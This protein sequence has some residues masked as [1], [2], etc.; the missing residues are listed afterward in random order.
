M[1]WLQQWSCCSEPGPVKLLLCPR[2][3]NR[4]VFGS[5]HRTWLQL[6]AGW[7]KE[8]PTHRHQLQLNATVRPICR[9]LQAGSAAA[10]ARGATWKH[11]FTK[12]EPKGFAPVPCWLMSV[13]DPLHIQANGHSAGTEFGNDVQSFWLMKCYEF[14]LFLCFD[15][16][17]LGLKPCFRLLNFFRFFCT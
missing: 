1:C 6:L 8:N 11:E 4:E 12:H 15:F 16:L 2:V 14:L 13:L 17:H 7:R 9:E 10:L 3:F 5:A